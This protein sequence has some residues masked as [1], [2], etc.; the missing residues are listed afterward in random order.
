[1]KPESSDLMIHE[2]QCEV[3]DRRSN[4]SNFQTEECTFSMTRN[5]DEG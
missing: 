5:M 2:I 1:M 4:E 3:Y